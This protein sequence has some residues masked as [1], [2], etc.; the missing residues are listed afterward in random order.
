MKI[1]FVVQRYGLEINGG[2]ELHCRW[3]AE[4]MRKYW[5]VQVLTTRAR[6]YITWKNHY[7]S[8]RETINGIRVRRFPTARSRDPERFGK[9]QKH[10]LEREHT[11]AD[12]LE[13]LKEE[14]PFA[15]DLIDFIR[16]H[17]DE[18]DYFVFFSYRYFHSY[19]GIAAVPERGILVPTAE[20]DD[21]IH[22]HLFKDLFR[23]PRALV[24]NSIEEREMIQGLARNQ[25]VPGDVVGVGSVIPPEYSAADFRRTFGI[26]GDYLI[27]IGRID[28]NK[29]C[30]ELFENFLGF[31][32]KT[33]SDIK[34]L[35]VGSPIIKV[36]PHEDI[37][38]LGFLSERDKFSALDGAL[39]LC[40]PSPYESLSMVTLEAWALG[41]PVLANG[42]CEVLKGQCRRSGAGLYYETGPQFHEALGL[43]LDDARLRGAMGDQGR[44][45]F[46]AN[47]SWDAVEGKY[48]DLVGS[49]SEA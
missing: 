26:E 5:D 7:T 43:L 47:Y 40:M 11:R 22:L 13:W 41:K 12:E 31:K 10:I 21:I 9:L 30:R 34:L 44:R 35:L 1:A 27:Y 49:L 8:G 16:A 18:F 36:P 24:Y 29:G 33:S 46:Q 39:L 20:R 32:R 15:P 3:V 4:H 6:D 45:Y 48:L 2:A 23:R 19:W 28:E 37:R 14:G 38:V 25:D 42:R 17:E